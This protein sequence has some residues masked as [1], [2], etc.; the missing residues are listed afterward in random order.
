MNCGIDYE[1]RTTLV[2]SFHTPNDM[3]DIAKMIKGAKKYYL[4][5]FVDSE[6]CLTRGLQEI[7]YKTAKEY[8]EICRKKVHNTYLRGY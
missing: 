3:H 4:Q 5:K 2:H 1:F 8:Q 7:D 6:N